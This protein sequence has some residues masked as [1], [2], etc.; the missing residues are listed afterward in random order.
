MSTASSSAGPLERAIRS[1]IA[2]AESPSGPLRRLLWRCRR[3]L[4]GH[5]RLELAYRVGVAVGGT[6]LVLGGL[7]LVPLPGPGW[8]VV[9]TGLAL[10]GTEFAWAH[11]VTAWL[12]RRLAQF[13][14]WW[15]ARRELRRAAR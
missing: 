8:L 3:W 13:W 15:R 10:L 11:R 6:V 5:R 12:K 7:V 2:V 9:F 1:D 4:V 14:T